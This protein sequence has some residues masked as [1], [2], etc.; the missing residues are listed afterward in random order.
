MKQKLTAGKESEN[1]KY[2]NLLAEN[3]AETAVSMQKR[4]KRI[5]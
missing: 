3:H 2:W 5:L 4:E 1:V